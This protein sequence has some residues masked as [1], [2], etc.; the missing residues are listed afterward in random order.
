MGL[1]L[2]DLFEYTENAYELTVAINK[3]S[4]QLAVLK[5]PEV[6]KSNGKV[7]PIALQQVI[8]KQIEYHFE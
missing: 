4:Y 8:N 3:R 5:T 7:V 1:P 6:E 2:E